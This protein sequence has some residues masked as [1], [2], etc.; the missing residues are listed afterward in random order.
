[1]LTVYVQYLH[2]PHEENTFLLLLQLH[3][4]DKSMETFDVG[5][6]LYMSFLLAKK[7]VRKRG[8]PSHLI[9]SGASKEKKVHRKDRRNYRILK[10]PLPQKPRE[11]KANTETESSSRGTF[12][13]VYPSSSLQRKIPSFPFHEE[14]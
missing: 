11:R 3:S 6:F 2:N 12:P 9:F 14:Q 4:I 5:R 1:M 7:V 10:I 13:L 8:S